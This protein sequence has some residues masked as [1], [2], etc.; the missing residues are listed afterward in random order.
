MG[1]ETKVFDDG[2]GVVIID[3]PVLSFKSDTSRRLYV[4]DKRPESSANIYRYIDG[5]VP[6]GLTREQKKKFLYDLHEKVM[7]SLNSL[8]NNNHKSETKQTEVGNN[9]KN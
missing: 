5:D 3:G 9:E 1:A 8:Q 6:P 2:N 7:I 4:K